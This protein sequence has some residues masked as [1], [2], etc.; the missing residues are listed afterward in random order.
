[1]ESKMIEIINYSRVTDRDSII[2]YVSIRLPR[3]VMPQTIIRRIPHFQK[4]ERRWFGLPSF[5]ETTETGKNYPR[6]WEFENQI[7]NSE[8]LEKLSELVKSYC[9][10]NKI[11]DV[12]SISFEPAPQDLADMM[13]F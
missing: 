4:G 7:H 11:A 2:G 8:L 3:M 1:M 6:F 5:T 13:P 10:E 9:L 12:E